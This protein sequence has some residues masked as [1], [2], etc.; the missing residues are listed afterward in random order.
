MIGGFH[1]DNG[2]ATASPALR[3]SASIRAI[4]AGGG[5]GRI[6]QS[7]TSASGVR[8]RYRLA[9]GGLG[10]S[11]AGRLL[12]AA[13]RIVADLEVEIA[14]LII[15]VEPSAD[16][17]LNM[18]DVAMLGHRG[19]TPKALAG[20][21]D[22][23]S[24]REPD[25]LRAHLPSGLRARYGRAAWFDDPDRLAVRRALPAP[26][27]RG[28]RV[29]E[30]RG[31]ASTGPVSPRPSSRLR[32]R[33]KGNDNDALDAFLEW[34]TGA[35]L[36]VVVGAGLL[37]DAFAA[38]GTDG[39]RALG[40]RGR[41]RRRHSDDGTGGWAALR[42]RTPGRSWSGLAQRGPDLPAGK[43]GGG[44][45]I[46]RS[47]GV[48]DTRVV[49]TGDDAVELASM[50]RPQKLHGRGLGLSLRMARYSQVDPHQIAVVGA[51]MKRLAGLYGADL[52]PLPI[53]DYFNERDAEVIAVRSDS[54]AGRSNLPVSPA[55]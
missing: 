39:A 16:H 9:Y 19:A 22:Q 40:R 4:I 7:T 33:L 41:S 28:T 17:L 37:T 15:L 45:P 2:A 18:G 26:L 35:D 12:C 38:D 27:E 30:R 8:R 11:V 53:S 49:T 6:T 44:G 23:R 42:C 29:L 21:F 54:L 20:R 32:R 36:V 34:A 14:G 47:L 13:A 51:V 3:C 46:L 48:S 25:R 24:G 5:A 10:K 55:L 1:V 52:V 43:A 50:S 31:F